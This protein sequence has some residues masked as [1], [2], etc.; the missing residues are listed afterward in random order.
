MLC[1]MHNPNTDYYSNS[2]T[3]IQR[4]GFQGWGNSLIDRLIERKVNRK[5]GMRILELGASS[6]E[7][8]KFV[9]V[10]LYG[11]NTFVWI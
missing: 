2:Y 4:T 9:K 1:P 5:E 6:G 8:L 7:H 11:V 10:F 3:V